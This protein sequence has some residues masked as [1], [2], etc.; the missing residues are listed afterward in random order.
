M[1][2]HDKE[3]DGRPVTKPLTTKDSLDILSE[4]DV[5]DFDTFVRRIGEEIAAGE[6]IDYVAHRSPSAGPHI[7]IQYHPD[8]QPSHPGR[9]PKSVPTRSDGP[10]PGWPADCPHDPPLGWSGV[11]ERDMF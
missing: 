9:D 2:N 3:V 1:T 8:S 5:T 7:H 6:V 10:P 11:R 4:P